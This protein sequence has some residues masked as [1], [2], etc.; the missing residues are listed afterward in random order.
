M[1]C[2]DG[3]S[4]KIICWQ[5]EKGRHTLPWQNTKDPYLVWVSEIMLQ[6]TTV[7]TVLR[8]Y[9][10]FVNR[11]PTV[12]SLGQATIQEV[13]FAW[14]GLG[15][16]R[17]A[18]NLHRSAQHIMDKGFFP[19][20]K[21]EW[22][23]LPGIGESTAAA[24]CV[25][26]YGQREAILDGNVKRVMARIFC[27]GGPVN[28]TQ[29]VNAL[30]E[31]AKKLLPQRDIEAYTQGLMDLGATV[32]L[33]KNPSCQQCPVQVHCCAH[34]SNKQDAYPEKQERPPLKA[35]SLHLELIKKNKKILLVQR[36]E[37]GIWPNLW[38]L[39]ETNKK[40]KK[41]NQKPLTEI[42]HRLTHRD[43][44]IVI[45]AGCYSHKKEEANT[46]F[47]LNDVKIGLPQPISQY[48]RSIEM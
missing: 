17:R 5:K 44:R 23:A 30:W 31:K 1:S 18:I 35:L 12:H 6:Q 46:W 20:N 3:F 42:Q 19:Q 37:K 16:Y 4:E 28:Q 7:A 14:A 38:C 21:A 43:L 22:C 10:A 27:V 39:P 47:D 36:P 15:Y 2:S 29:A 11:F 9:S 8:Y 41:V 32:C 24:L 48:L 45:W 33:R 40:K 26:C 13:M 25:F 34:Q